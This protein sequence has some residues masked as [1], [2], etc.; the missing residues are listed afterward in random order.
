MTELQ[1][2]VLEY[3]VSRRQGQMSSSEQCFKNIKGLDII[4]LGQKL[5]RVIRERVD[6]YLSKYPQEK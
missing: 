3:E 1:N 6:D 5:Y 4:C 2:L